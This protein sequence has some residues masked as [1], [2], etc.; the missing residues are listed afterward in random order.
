VESLADFM[1]CDFWI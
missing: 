1:D